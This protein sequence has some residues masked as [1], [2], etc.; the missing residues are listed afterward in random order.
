MERHFD[1]ELQQFKN[2]LLEMATLTEE[3][4]YKATEALKTRDTER[5]NEVFINDEK[6]DAMEI[7][8]EE[9]GIN[10]LATR[11]PMAADLRFITTGIK[12]NAELERI[13]D[14]AVNIS[15]RA[16]ELAALDQEK[17]HPALSRLSQIA[18]T[19]LKECIDAFVMSD[20]DKAKHVILSDH[21]ANALK[22]LIQSDLTQEMVI[23]GAVTPVALPIILAA[24]HL[25]RICDHTTYI[26]EDIIYMLK[27]T[28]VK[29]HRNEL[30]GGAAEENN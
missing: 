30:A 23:D 16:V 15:Q 21:E 19:M 24:R 13:A 27:A 22:N 7:R 10:L 20:G 18:R 12:I 26:S 29:H 2:A 4:I 17:E 6:I 8:I 11:Q 25:E 5:A 9:Y 14:L 1:E 3:S 28:M